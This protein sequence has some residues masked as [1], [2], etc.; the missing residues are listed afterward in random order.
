M[1]DMPMLGSIGGTV[2]Q[3]TQQNMMQSVLGQMLMFQPTQSPQYNDY[4][5]DPSMNIKGL[6]LQ[7]TGT[8]NQQFHRPYVATMSNANVTM[9]GRRVEEI[10]QNNPGSD[11][12]PNLI[13]GLCSGIITPSATHEGTVSIVNGWNE[14]RF[15]FIL[16]VEV[17][18]AFSCDIYVYQGYSEFYDASLITGQADPNMNFFINSVVRLQRSR[19]ENEFGFIDRI[20]ETKQFIDGRALSENGNMSLDLL[21]PKDVVSVI[22][23]NYLKSAYGGVTFNDARTNAVNTTHSNIRSNGIPSK[24]L[25]RTITGHRAS[26]SLQSFG[27]GG[28][29][30]FDRT[31]QTLNEQS[32]YENPFIR[33]LT[34]MSGV[35][36]GAKTTFTLN[37]LTKI[38]PMIS[39]KV[40]YSP[41]DQKAPLHQAGAS[42]WM[43][44]S[45]IETILASMISN[46]LAGLMVEAGLAQVAFVTTTMTPTGQPDTRMLTPG[47][48]MTTMNSAMAYQQFISAFNATLMPD[49]SMNFTLPF[50]ATITA[51]LFGDIDI[52]IQ[53][54]GGTPERAVFPVFA[55]ALIISTATRSTENLNKMAGS[56]NDIMNVCGFSSFTNPDIADFDFAENL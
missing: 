49:L 25:A 7:E 54:D 38:D 19:R 16:V 21:R 56:V 33:K 42:M 52:F 9:L 23:S 47:V 20:A 32:P 2:H 26:Q 28:E 8:Y 12:Q 15:R 14:R 3:P 39:A 36:M 18:N 30:V 43:N 34:D 53:I 44:G 40:S 46:G 5:S 11:I 10:T 4:L 35:P 50:A 13:A 51:D 31:I 24:Y 27:E 22:Q 37:E 48:A 6:F 1:N 17:P 29:N 55:D 45:N 41:V